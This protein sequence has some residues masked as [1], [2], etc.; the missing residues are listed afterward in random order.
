MLATATVYESQHQQQQKQQHGETW[1]AC[2]ALE[3]SGNGA[4][5][6]GGQH[7]SNLSTYPPALARTHSKQHEQMRAAALSR[8]LGAEELVQAYRTTLSEPLKSSFTPNEMN[9]V[10]STV[11]TW[12]DAE[13]TTGSMGLFCNKAEDRN[14]PKGL[15]D[16]HLP[17]QI[18]SACGQTRERCARRPKV[19]DFNGMAR[20]FSQYKNQTIDEPSSIGHTRKELVILQAVDTREDE[21]YVRP[22][23]RQ[24]YGNEAQC[25]LE[26]AE[27][28]TNAWPSITREV[29]E[30]S[31][32]NQRLVDESELYIARLLQWVEVK[33]ELLG[34]AQ[35]TLYL[36]HPR[37]HDVARS[38]Y[39]PSA[40]HDSD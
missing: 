30:R 25:A 32:N 9:A 6:A 11:V 1:T 14:E 22:I 13:A 23:I 18:K 21:L 17:D 33:R 3:P 8:S 5:E 19:V 4:D 39:T 34:C 2:C 29:A 24:D 27:R 15:A 28:I 40:D 37:N 26:W 10:E 38:R 20:L 7:G 36:V 35:S 16:Q 31:R 12:E